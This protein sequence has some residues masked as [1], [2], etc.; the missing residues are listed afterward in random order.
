M[1]CDRAIP[2]ERA[3]EIRTRFETKRKQ[4]QATVEAEMKRQHFAKSAELEAAKKAE[5]E[6]L[7]L[8]AVAL[9]SAPDVAKHPVDVPRIAMFSTWT[10]TQDVGWVRYAFDN[11]QSSGQPDE[12]PRPSH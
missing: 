2:N 6:T 1:A 4:D 12:G 5:I 7:G 3:V 8:K 10:S 11:M 9:A